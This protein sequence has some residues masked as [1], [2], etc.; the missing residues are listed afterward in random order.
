MKNIILFGCLLLLFLVSGCFKDEG[1]YVYESL[2][3]IPTWLIDPSVE[4]IRVNGTQGE[5][6][7]FRP[8]GKDF[9]FGE[10]SVNMVDKVRYEWEVK[11]II[12]STESN[13]DMPTDTVMKRIKFDKAENGVTATFRIIYKS[14][15]V[16][17]TARAYMGLRPKYYNGN[18]IILSENGENTKCSYFR[19][20]T[21]ADGNK[22]VYYFDLEDD[23]YH[24]VSGKEIIGKALRL[25]KTLSPQISS[26]VG[27]SII[28]TDKQAYVLNDETFL[29]HTELK[30]QFLDGVPENF[31]AVDAV[32]NLHY[33][34]VATK[35]GRL[36]K[37]QMS[38]NYL[39]GKFLTAPYVVD[40]KGYKV[41]K[42]GQYLSRDL[43]PLC[44]DELN[45]RILA[46]QSDYNGTNVRI[47]PLEKGDGVNP[48]PLWD[49][50]ADIEILHM[51]PTYSSATYNTGFAIYYNQNGNTYKYDFKYNATNMRIIGEVAPVQLSRNLDKNTTFLTT[52]SYSAPSD[53]LIYANGNELRYI[54]FGRDNTDEHWMTLDGRVTTLGYTTY[55]N[56]YKFMIVGCEN[57]DIIM[58]SVD[59][60]TMDATVLSK[61]NVGGKIVDAHESG[62]MYG[63]DSY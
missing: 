2:G 8:Q 51:C 26:S 22:T 18:I 20:K 49:L 57:G 1:N 6:M 38:E 24:K 9:T 60:T 35:D 43:Q 34:L 55:Y 39:S 47:R 53:K 27:A 21:R 14:S 56:P 29:M 33:T 4:P 50:P 58:Y 54:D 63:V 59:R 23:L 25:V 45:R 48:L 28:V 37:R 3:V 17:F 30:D 42:F 52:A 5:I 12:F 46:V 13:F 41:T 15:G 10:D 19:M 44:F 36:F 16:T 31:V 62:F 7:K 32:D 40:G 61:A 11:G